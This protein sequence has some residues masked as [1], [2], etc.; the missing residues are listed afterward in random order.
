[1]LLVRDDCVR[2]N[3]RRY[4]FWNRFETTFFFF[5]E[6]L[7]RC[8]IL[9]CKLFNT[10]RRSSASCYLSPRAMCGTLMS[11]K[12]SLPDKIQD[13]SLQNMQSRYINCNIAFDDACFTGN[14]HIPTGFGSASSPINKMTNISTPTKSVLKN[15]SV[16]CH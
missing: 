4:V 13:A 1:M 14:L 16:T 2:G 15:C 3:R 11:Q 6:Y 9:R 10:R 12:D 7:S 8:K 5:Q